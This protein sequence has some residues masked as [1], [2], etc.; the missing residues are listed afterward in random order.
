MATKGMIRTDEGAPL[1]GWLQILIEDIDNER[2]S[3]D[4]DVV[5]KLRGGHIL[6]LTISE[7][8][9]VKKGWKFWK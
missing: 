3:G 8:P 2:I 1:S 7:K 4:R 5:V 6:S 9:P